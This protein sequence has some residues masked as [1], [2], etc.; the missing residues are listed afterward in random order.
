MH[1]SEIYEIETQQ[2]LDGNK[3]YDRSKTV[4]DKVLNDTKE[5]II[6]KARD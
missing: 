6:R 2:Y 3:K 1:G 4:T 5:M